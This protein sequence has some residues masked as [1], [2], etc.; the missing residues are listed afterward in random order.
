MF[1]DKPAR[2]V[3]LVRT[4]PCLVTG[5]EFDDGGIGHAHFMPENFQSEPAP[6]RFGKI[7]L[8]RARLG[9][10]AAE[11]IILELQHI[12]RVARA[13][14][15]LGVWRHLAIVPALAAP[16][17]RLPAA[18]RT[19][20]AKLLLRLHVREA[21]LISSR[22]PGRRQPIMF[23]SVADWGKAWKRWPPRLEPVW[24]RSC[25]SRRQTR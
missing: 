6:G 9:M 24:T 5:N 20:S 19:R 10:P 4:S 12:S 18:A 13:H 22:R 11:Q 15:R 3:Q 16:F 21:F 2:F 23:Y 1:A 8:Y 14:Q 7:E 25:P 17:I